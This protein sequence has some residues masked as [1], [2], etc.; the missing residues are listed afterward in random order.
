HYP[1]EERPAARPS[2]TTPVYHLFKERGA[3]FG[4]RFGWE[5]PNFFRPENPVDDLSFRRANWFDTVGDE[6][7]ACRDSVGMLDLSGFSKWIVRGANAEQWLESIL[8][9]KM[10]R[11]K[12]ALRLVHA[13][14]PNGGTRSEF[15]ITRMAEDKFYMVSAGGA[16]Q[17]DHDFLFKSLPADG[18]VT[19]ENV[20]MT[21]G[22]FVLAGPNS[23]AVLEKLADTDLS[24]KALP[25]L[26]GVTADVGMVPSALILRVNFVGDLGYEIHHP[27][28][29]QTALF[30]DLEE[31][32][33]E[34][35]MRLLGLRAMESMRLEK[36]YRMWGL[37]LTQD[38]SPL[39]A[40][41]DRFVKLDNRDFTGR[42]ALLAEMENG[43]PDTLVTL[44]VDVD[45]ADC[46]G[47]EPIY[48]GDTMIG[49]VTSGGYGHRIEK[50]LGIGFV[51]TGSAAIGD[52]VSILI[53][54]D[55]RP[56]RIIGESPF[57]PDNLR[58]RA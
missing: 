37:E 14:H 12:M 13:L 43:I 45:D 11:K 31:A 44:E 25:W 7:R 4:Q 30:Y 19:L 46:F 52:E 58:L 3:V 18:S 2:K 15:T 26:N 1:L 34:F 5:R 51:K 20:T 16:E 10:P 35:G 27:I 53:L 42:A 17:Y 38:Y 47:N 29:H 32:G 24:T 33:K 56:A 8:A 21:T 23:R 49:R 28:E 9:N 50:S 36:S 40:G 55:K 48:R 54:G 39:A 41:L 22:V 6:C 57:D